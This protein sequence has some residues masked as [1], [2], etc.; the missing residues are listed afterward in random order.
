MAWKKPG[1]VWVQ[2]GCCTECQGC[3][4]YYLQETAILS[5]GQVWI[6]GFHR[7]RDCGASLQARRCCGAESIWGADSGL[8]VANMSFFWKKIYERM[9]LQAHHLWNCCFRC[10]WRGW[11]VCRLSFTATKPGS[12]PAS[13]SSW[14]R[15]Q[16]GQN[17]PKVF[18][19]L[20]SSWRLRPV[21]LY[22]VLRRIYG[23]IQRC[24]LLQ[25]LSIK[26]L[27]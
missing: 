12:L 25:G 7:S 23:E 10:V 14:S 8:I 15:T 19:Y 27:S 20:Y 1:E 9:I 2:T 5:S 22:V 13:S 26:K 4:K 17:L 21:A 18:L 6:C 24:P 3:V 16:C 11:M